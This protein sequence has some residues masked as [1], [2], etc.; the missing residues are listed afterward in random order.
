MTARKARVPVV[1]DTNIFVRNF[2]TRSK[3]SPNRRIVRLWLLQRRLQLIL[4]H[5]VLVEYLEI[6]ADILL[7]D[8][9]VVQDW[10]RRFE[11][12]DRCT[13][14]NLAHR[15][16]ASR[17]PDDNVFLATA[18]AGHADYL[19]SNDRDLLELPES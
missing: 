9:E 14:V 11:E 16:N 19:I 17:D 7:M 15:Y 6:F 4:S 5:D 1:L 3:T 8:D 13:M 2:K 10:R 18:K 12:D